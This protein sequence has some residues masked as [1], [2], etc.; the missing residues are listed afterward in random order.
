MRTDLVF[1]H[2][3]IANEFRAWLLHYSLPVLCGVLPSVYLLH[4]ALLVWVIHTLLLDAIPRTRL[5]ERMREFA[6]RMCDDFD[7][8]VPILYD[9][10]FLKLCKESTTENK[11]QH[12]K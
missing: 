5:A 10:Y 4:F 11:Q 8:L 1:Y 12:I 9:L 6:E 3:F 2:F 7:Q